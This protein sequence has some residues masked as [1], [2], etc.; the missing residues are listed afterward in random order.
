M[1]DN[2]DKIRIGLIGTGMIGAAHTMFLK[3]ICSLPNMNAELSAVSDINEP[4]GREFGKNFGYKRFFEKPVELIR[5]GEVDVVY[6]CTPT[7][8]HPDL[9]FEAADKKLHIFCEKP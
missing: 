2:K 1:S 8:G 9:T 6:I 7:S 3:Q 5:S 4:R